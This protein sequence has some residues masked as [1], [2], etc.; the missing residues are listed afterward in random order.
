MTEPLT[1]E[2]F[3]GHT[4]EHKVFLSTELDKEQ[5]TKLL[6]EW[7]VRMAEA[8]DHLD[9]GKFMDFLLGSVCNLYSVFF[10]RKERYP[11]EFQRVEQIARL[12]WQIS[13]ELRIR[14]GDT[15]PLSPSMVQ[16][17]LVANAKKLKALQF[18]LMS[19]VENGWKTMKN[20]SDRNIIIQWG[21][22][23]YY[24]VYGFQSL[25]LVMPPGQAKIKDE[26]EVLMRKILSRSPQGE[27]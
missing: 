27:Q 7:L 1:F 18:G 21:G 16:E 23:Y 15:V 9:L 6:T 13:D 22:I 12:M 26:Y 2:Q 10:E 14:F 8:K 3:L 17:E 11:N 20:V 19:V 4:T 5:K 24:N 25:S